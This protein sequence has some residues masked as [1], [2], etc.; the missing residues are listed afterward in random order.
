MS[1]MTAA[2]DVHLF[3][4]APQ[5]PAAFAVPRATLIEAI[6]GHNPTVTPSFLA[7]FSDD[8]LTHY[9]QHLEWGEKPRMMAGAW[10]DPD[11]SAAIECAEVD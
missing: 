6:K 9:L 5:A 11:H 7:D 10:E 1:V 3:I 8:E 4:E 2:N